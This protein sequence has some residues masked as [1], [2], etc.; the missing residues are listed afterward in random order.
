MIALLAQGLA[1]LDAKAPPPLPSQPFFQRFF[2]ESPTVVVV[3]AVGISLVAFAILGTRG[4]PRQARI[5]AAAGALTASIV[6]ALATLI[7]T[8]QEKM[9]NATERM[10][11]AVAQADTASLEELLTPDAVLLSPLSGQ[12]LTRDQVLARIATDFVAGRPY[13]VRDH[14]V[15]A[16]QASMDGERAGRVQVKVRITPDDGPPTPVWVRLDFEKGPDGEWRA[17]GIAVLSVGGIAGQ[18]R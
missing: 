13:H 8:D 12:P 1:G 6:I 3:I 11:H 17:G 7:E 15:L 14:R 5:A 18:L 4:R 2:L 10:I 16:M 9:E